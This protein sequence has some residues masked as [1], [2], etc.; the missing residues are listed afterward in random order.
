MNLNLSNSYLKV[1][2]LSVISLDVDDL[3]HV[4]LL[5]GVLV[6]SLDYHHFTTALHKVLLLCDLNYHL[7]DVVAGLIV[8][9]LEAPNASNR[10]QIPDNRVNGGASKHRHR[11]SVL[12]DETCDGPSIRHTNDQIYVQVQYR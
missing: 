6:L 2:L 3:H 10:L 12:S 1:S 9:D 11:R 4:R 7:H 5:G 8:R